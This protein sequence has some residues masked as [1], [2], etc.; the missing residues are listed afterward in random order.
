M[1]NELVLKLKLS[2]L[3]MPL[4]WNKLAD[5]KVN[6]IFYIYKFFCRVHNAIEK[7]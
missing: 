4:Q 7:L 3:D 6:N 5:F 1:I 2:F